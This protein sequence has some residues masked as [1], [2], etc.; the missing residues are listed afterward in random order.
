[1]V[2]E[3]AIFYFFGWAALLS[4]GFAMFRFKLQPYIKQIILSSLLLDYISML[5]QSSNNLHLITTIQPL[6]AIVCYWLIFRLRWIYAI[7]ITVA[8]YS[9][10]F[11]LEFF[12]TMVAANFEIKEFL[13]AIQTQDDLAI[14][15]SIIFIDLIMCLLLNKYRRGFTFI[16]RHNM[17]PLTFLKHNRRLVAIIIIAL[18]V[19]MLSSFTLFHFHSNIALVFQGLVVILWFVILKESYQKEAAE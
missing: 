3:W 4:M 14:G 13:D 10:N 12:M 8:A 19:L 5:L 16:P 11:I 2:I 1:M 15:I 6:S 7:I 18:I 17:K 9:I